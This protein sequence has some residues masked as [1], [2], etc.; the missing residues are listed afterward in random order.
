[1]TNEDLQRLNQH[2]QTKY[3]QDEEAPTPIPAPEETPQPRYQR[4]RRK[5]RW[6]GT[7]VKANTENAW[8]NVKGSINV[9]QRVHDYKKK[10]PYAQTSKQTMKGVRRLAPPPLKHVQV[11]QVQRDDQVRQHD[12]TPA[13]ERNYFSRPTDLHVN[14]GTVSDPRNL[15]DLVGNQGPG[16]NADKYSFESLIG[17][18]NRNKERRLY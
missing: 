9:K 1:M 8:N 11:R 16:F 18:N 3:S 2:I 13:S 5:A 10:N 6:V 4:F 12:I 7:G 14:T 17:A 15:E